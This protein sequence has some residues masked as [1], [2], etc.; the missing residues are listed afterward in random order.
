MTGR[1]G[2]EAA[3]PVGP[4]TAPVVV[5]SNR[6]PVELAAGP[7]AAGRP[8]RGGGGLIAILGSALV[9][10]GGVWVVAGT[11]HTG[12]PAA[13]TGPDGSTPGLVGRA[14]LVEL[15]QGR[16]AVRVVELAPEIYRAYYGRIANR[17]LWFLHHQLFDLSRSPTFG[18]PFRADWRAYE[19]V[20][21]AVAD[22]CAAEVAP[23]GTV[24]LQDYHLAVAPAR[25][26]A[27]R[28]DVRI[29][30]C[31]MC[32]WA[33][34]SYFATLPGWA[35][36]R[37]LAGML[38]ADE[39]SFFVP[40]W[41]RS[42]LR[43]CADLGYDVDWPTWRVRAPGG[44]GHTATVR[45]V[46]VGVDVGRLQ[47]RL[48]TPPVR[49]EAAEVASLVG[50]RRL[51]LRVDRLDPAKNILRGVAGYGAFLAGNPARHG[52]VLH[53]VL[54]YQSRADLPEYQRYAGEVRA[55]VDRLRRR[56]RTGSWEPVVLDTRNNIDRALAL[57]ARA[58]VLVVNPVRDGM[59][60][61][62]KEAAAVSQRDVAV[63][64]SRHAGAADELAAGSLVIDPFDTVELADAIAAAL[65]LAPAER[66][67]RLALLRAAA[68]AVPPR[69]WLDLLLTGGSRSD[70]AA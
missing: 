35:A 13:R 7:E 66:G 22:A 52:E 67:R 38:G 11:R 46:P 19:H 31:T 63:I 36:H 65:A 6:G 54:A 12:A 37:L 18:P 8:R 56:F 68:G 44:G 60:L 49:A 53:Y 32:P 70:G 24:L 3:S 39:L 14:R 2:T 61:V 45:V 17:I 23:G 48:T 20:N 58:D 27:R 33:E 34:P 40:R 55:A 16:V 15:P 51:I 57:M 21:Q 64:L 50:D 30:H 9:G 42:F 69:R 43:C 25:L 41:A 10:S 59:N 26:R 47:A 4:G 29:I 28:P 5:A 1:G 62:V